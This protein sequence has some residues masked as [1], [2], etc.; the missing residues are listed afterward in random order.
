MNDPLNVEQVNSTPT[1]PL[2]VVQKVRMSELADQFQSA[3]SQGYVEA[4]VLVRL[5]D[6][7]KELLPAI[8]RGAVI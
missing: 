1:I 5:L 4:N 7:A 3:L 6:L 2:T 8:V